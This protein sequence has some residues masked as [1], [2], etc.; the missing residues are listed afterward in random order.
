M[1]TISTHRIPCTIT[2]PSRIVAETSEGIRVVSSLPDTTV[3][4]RLAYGDEVAMHI[5][6][7]RKLMS[8]VQWSGQMV[9]GATKKGFMFVFTDSPTIT[10]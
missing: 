7:V 8:K 6:V 10:F 5:A 9:C 1:Q 3:E 4:D 2:K